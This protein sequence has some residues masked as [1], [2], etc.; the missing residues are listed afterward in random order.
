M[1]LPPIKRPALCL[2]AEGRLLNQIMGHRI[3]RVC[4]L[5]NQNGSGS[6][7]IK[8]IGM[9]VYSHRNQRDR[10]HNLDENIQRRT[11]GIF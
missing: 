1:D 5:K 9:A 11:D 10:G 6:E 3:I 8:Q 2:A 7:E 4:V